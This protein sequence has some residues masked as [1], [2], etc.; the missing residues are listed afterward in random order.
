MSEGIMYWG[1]GPPT[2][3]HPPTA[4]PSIHTPSTS[5]QRG[6]HLFCYRNC[7]GL[8]RK[9][10]SYSS[11]RRQNYSAGTGAATFLKSRSFIRYSTAP[12]GL[13]CRRNFCRDNVYGR[14]CSVGTAVACVL[15]MKNEISASTI[16]CGKIGRSLL[17]F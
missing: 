11:N 3:G 6:F 5:T 12:L 7:I 16:S 14:P 9:T 17:L 8:M 10:D 4:P 15:Y 2:C 1:R 13:R